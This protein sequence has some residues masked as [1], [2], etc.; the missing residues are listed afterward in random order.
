M[1]IGIDA[2][3]WAESGVG[4]Y[5]RNLIFEFGKIDNN[6]EYT[7]F[8]TSK[9]YKN[10]KSQ[11][12]NLKFS[13]NYRIIPTNIRWHSIEEQIKFPSIL[14]KEN[15]DL[16][17]FPY[18]SIPIFYNRAF[19]VTIHDL[20][21]H[22]FPTGQATTKSSLVYWSKVLAYKLIIQKAAINARKI[23]TVSNSTKD[24]IINLLKVPSKKITVIYEGVN[25]S[26]ENK[27]SH[28][29]NFISDKVSKAPYLLH[30]GNLYPHKNMNLVLKSLKKIKEINN[31]NLPLVIVGKSDYFTQKFKQIISSSKL[32][33][34]VIFLGEVSDLE[35]SELYSNALAY[36]SPSLMEGFDLP[37][38]EAMSNECLLLLSDIPVHH[39]ICNNA[40]LYFDIKDESGLVEILKDLIKNRDTNY[41]DKIK[42]GTILAKK[43]N[44]GQMAKETLKIYENSLSL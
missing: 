6:N 29:S 10:I 19:V 39:E 30:V 9:D 16:I 38:A 11:I 1:K 3:F 14:N 36:I 22:H 25:I 32:N 33:D 26:L 43:Y 5:V 24:E 21:L 35:L 13:K 41:K 34:Q 37:V 40:A 31:I 7:L 8:V 15:L 4:R 27:N 23:I 18:F 17:H 42:K 44:W 12:S 2:R 28:S 20:I